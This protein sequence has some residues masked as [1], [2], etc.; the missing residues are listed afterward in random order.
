MGEEKLLID[1]DDVRV[2][3]FDCG[4]CH[5]LPRGKERELCRGVTINCKTKCVVEP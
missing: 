2:L 4:G 3:G 5:R 1:D